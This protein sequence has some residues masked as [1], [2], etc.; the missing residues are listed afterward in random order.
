M[1]EI[2]VKSYL[3]EGRASFIVNLALRILTW[4]GQANEHLSTS[5]KLHCCFAHLSYAMVVR[6]IMACASVHYMISNLVLRRASMLGNPYAVWVLICIA[7]C[8]HVGIPYTKFFLI[9]Q[10]TIPGI[11]WGTFEPN[12]TEMST[13]PSTR[14]P[15]RHDNLQMLGNI[16][17]YFLTNIKQICHVLIFWNF[18]AS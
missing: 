15:W 6:A 18:L 14:T 9:Q 1:N 7:L 13:V 2:I 16:Q 3:S 8:T 17:K 12:Q 4:L 11:Q 5:L 10:L